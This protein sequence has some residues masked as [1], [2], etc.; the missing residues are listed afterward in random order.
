MTRTTLVVLLAIVPALAVAQ[1]AAPDAAVDAQATPDAAAVEGLDAAAAPGDRAGAEGAPA[2]A[3]PDTYTVKPGDT[4]WDL[5]GRFLNNPW[6]WPKIWSYNPEITNP[7]W[8]YPGN[9][10]KFFPSADE[11]PQRVAPVGPGTPLAKGDAGG[12]EEVAELTR[13]LDDL[14]KADMK[15]P[16]SA[17]EADAVAVAG[18]YKIGYV[19]KRARLAR[20]DTF[21]TRREIAESGAIHAAAEEKLMLA[22]LDRAYARF[23]QPADVK[24]GESYVVYRTERPIYHPTRRELL[25]YQSVVLGTAKVTAVEDKAA[26]LQI[27]QAFEPIER[28][29]LLG[30]WT[31]KFL[32][33]VDRKPNKQ[34]L[35][36]RIVG[37]QVDVMT[38]LG[39]HHVVFL[40]RGQRDGV[41]EGNV[42]TVLRSGDPYGKNPNRAQWDPKLPIEAIGELLVVDVKE[43]ASTALVTKSLKELLI[44][45]RIEMRA[46][47]GAGGR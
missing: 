31:Q 44:G 11:G 14:S 3:A 40:D 27:V 37:A 8:I 43:T 35:D 45:D 36:G 33:P 25:G 30:P 15:A 42:F 34:D 20:H 26:T 10:L 9:I 2:G 46:G 32:R 24:V 23:D 18:P 12:D 16:A 47:A 38:Q 7:H 21:V 6:Y 22:N 29:A 41:E 28:G 13:E 4:L 5:S 19:P 1:E 17:E 39:E